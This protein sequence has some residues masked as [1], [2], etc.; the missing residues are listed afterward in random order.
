MTVGRSIRAPA[1]CATLSMCAVLTACHPWMY[2]PYRV[3]PP[4]GDSLPQ[5]LQRV[6]EVV[7]RHSLSPE[8]WSDS[9]CQ[10]GSL[11]R[12]WDVVVALQEAPTGVLLLEVSQYPAREWNDVASAVVSELEAALSSYA[13]SLVLMPT[14]Y[15]PNVFCRDE[16]LRYRSEGR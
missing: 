8:E 9:P 5:V 15:T 4:A 12:R 2:A 16:A 10:L 13:D 14:E 6:S 3:V 1:S 7:T 11:W